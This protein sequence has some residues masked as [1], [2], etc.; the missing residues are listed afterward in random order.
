M[1]FKNPLEAITF[2]A[3]VTL[4][5]L[6]LTADNS[7]SQTASSHLKTKRPK[8][9]LV[10]RTS[11]HPFLGAKMLILGQGY[12]F[13]HLKKGHLRRLAHNFYELPNLP[14]TL[15]Q[16]LLGRCWADAGWN[17]RLENTQRKW[18]PTS[19]AWKSAFP[20]KKLTFRKLQDLPVILDMSHA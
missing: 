19:E 2:E 12:I 4:P 14:V 17:I 15:Q 13:Q 3:W 1:T 5:S 6:K 18:P 9:K 16:L 8:R 7:S 11:N 10:V 20:V